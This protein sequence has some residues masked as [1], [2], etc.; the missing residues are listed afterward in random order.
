MSDVVAQEMEEMIEEQIAPA[1]NTAP[2]KIEIDIDHQSEMV[3]GDTLAQV[4]LSML[5]DERFDSAISEL[6]YY[7]KEKNEI[8]NF[9]TRTKGYFKHCIEI[10]EKLKELANLPNFNNLRTAK[11]KEMREQMT[12]LAKEVKDVLGRIE[13]VDYDL[14]VQDVRSTVW[15]LKTFSFCVLSLAF[16]TALVEALQQLSS[17]FTTV[18][19]QIVAILF[20]SF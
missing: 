13:K 16:V 18:A 17:P 2:K 19:E 5:V 14:R 15:V 6:N 20:Y 1:A 3:N 10:V 8:P 7:Q 11:Q 12:A 4:I 9:E